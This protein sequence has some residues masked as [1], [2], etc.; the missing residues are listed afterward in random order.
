M[1]G[2]AISEHHSRSDLRLP[3]WSLGAARPRRE[4]LTEPMTA[5]TET[6]AICS[7]EQTPLACSRTDARSIHRAAVKDMLNLREIERILV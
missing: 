3:T 6:I 2:E 7:S 5:V 1:P 4:V